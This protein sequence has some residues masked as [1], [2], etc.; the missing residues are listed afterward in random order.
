MIQIMMPSLL[1]LIMKNNMGRDPA[2]EARYAGN[3]D[4]A[5]W[6]DDIVLR[7]D[8]DGTRRTEAKVAEM[9]EFVKQDK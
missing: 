9:I 5:Q 4:L 1:F 3:D 2:A 6:L 7:L 8:R